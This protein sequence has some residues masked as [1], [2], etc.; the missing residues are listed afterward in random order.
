MK[1]NTLSA[2]L[3]LLCKSLCSKV[4]KIEDYQNL[5]SQDFNKISSFLIH[6]NPEFSSSKE[7]LNKN[8][9]NW[10]LGK[11]T[12]SSTKV[13]EISKSLGYSGYHDF[14]HQNKR[15]IQTTRL[16]HSTSLT[17]F[18]KT[19]LLCGFALLMA[20]L[21]PILTG[22]SIEQPNTNPIEGSELLASVIQAVVVIIFY[23]I[24]RFTNF[25]GRDQ[26]YNKSSD[27]PTEVTSTLKQFFRGWKNLWLSFS[28]LY[29]WFC[30][31]YG[32]GIST[33]A[34]AQSVSDVI[35]IFSSLCFA[36][37]FSVMDVVS[38][39]RTQSSKTVNTFYTYLIIF[40]IG[41]SI[42]SLMSI[43][44]RY[45]NLGVLDGTGT[46]LLGYANVIVML[47][48]FGRLES[49]YLNVNRF[50]LLPLYTYAIIQIAYVIF[51]EAKSD[52][53]SF[54]ASIIGMVL[55]LKG[56]LY[57]LIRDWIKDGK[58]ENYFLQQHQR[59]EEVRN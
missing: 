29:I 49:H 50:V 25:G 54:E 6:F 56:F 10:F 40:T 18:Q 52:E 31:L 22:I 33:N 2:D 24:T 11:N 42:C 35:M 32:W 9:Q 13:E 47:Y 7:S 21:F 16:R 4:L 55:I 12:P 8:L 1:K 41:L 46:Y 58:M 44:D 53:P 48:F 20:V 3:D 26:I 45:Y 43:L 15:K 57:F 17:P 51:F 5:N 14:V 23:I 34:Y 39:P 27:R 30:V 19:A 59:N 36:Y 28:I 37:L 38:I